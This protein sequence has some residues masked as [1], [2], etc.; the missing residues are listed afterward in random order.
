MKK[1][2]S[3]I[4]A[5]LVA[6]LLGG[7][8]PLAAM[9]LRAD[10]APSPQGVLSPEDTG[11]DVSPERGSGADTSNADTT[12]D[13]TPPEEREITPLEAAQR[14]N[15]LGIMTGVGKNP[16]G[17]VNFALDRAITRQEA[18]TLIA[19]AAGYD[20]SGADMDYP[21]PFTDV[22]GFAQGS[23]GFAYQK[24][25]TNGVSKTSFNASAPMTGRELVTFLLRALGYGDD[26]AWSE[27]CAFADSVGLTDG[28]L[29]RGLDAVTRGDAAK[30]ML[31]LL[32]AAPKGLKMNYLSRLVETGALTREKVAAAGLEDDLYAVIPAA[33]PA[34]QVAA[35]LKNSLVTIT[36]RDIL[37]K[38]TVTAHGA[39]LA[40]GL[41]AAPL[42]AVK[43]NMYI[44]LTDSA[45]AVLAFTGILGHD[46]E[47]GLVYL[48]YT[49]ASGSG[50]APLYASVAPGAGQE[51]GGAA[52]DPTADTTADTSADTTADTI[53]DATGGPSTEPGAEAG[54]PA[55]AESVDD[56][57]YAVSDLAVAFARGEKLC[58]QSAS[59]ITDD[60]GT[61]LGIAT[62][63]GVW[64]PELEPGA[65]LGP[66]E[67]TAAH[68]PELL[69]PVY[70]R[71]IDPA[72]P[73]TAVTYDDGP[74][75]SYTP[76]LLDILEQYGA[77]ATF[78]EVGYRVA[79]WPQFIPRMESLHCEVANHTWDHAALRRLSREGVISQVQRTDEAI[80]AVTGHKVN[81][82]RC[83]GGNSNEVVAG[84][85]GHPI[86]YWTIDTRDWE[87]RVA[88]NVI[89]HVK[90]A[91]DLDGD[92]ILMHSLY[93]ST[94]EASR[95]IIPYI[96]NSGYQ[97]VT[98]SELAFFRGVEL[99][100]GVTY[101]KFPPQ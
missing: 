59:I 35:A 41:V 68:W 76:M 75:T 22:S 61:P 85:V 19:R 5:V 36:A 8:V 18:V 23:V 25:I 56:L 83:P 38:T 20:Q 69:P 80:E 86:I 4:A 1:C 91:G 96:L 65:P 45:G 15:T 11:A 17:T 50:P 43:G 90:N 95:T 70:P 51:S 79:R 29:G 92:I 12:V 64:R 32:T 100:N 39:V 31:K 33:V 66:Y 63:T 78:F 42:E 94:V 3:L 13:S 87:V 74:S 81:L 71:G 24:G 62:L 34:R 55:P 82:M 28:E 53:H 58:V 89:A 10:A 21:H 72:K 2:A 60:R 84:A 46:A 47:R 48:G 98:V 16:D 54:E 7:A 14:L 40:P 52:E 9:E 88:S 30:I 27:A 99:Q 67:Y 101:K 77:V 44:T 57:L 97:T 49:P 93:P 73:M 26:F 6:A 37:L